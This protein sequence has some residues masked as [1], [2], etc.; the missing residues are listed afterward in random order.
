MAY[1]EEACTDRQIHVTFSTN[2]T[3]CCDTC[4]R[5]SGATVA[6]SPT[7]DTQCEPCI[8][9]KTFN[10]DPV[11][12]DST[13]RACATCDNNTHFILHPC[14]ATHNTLCVC[15]DGS[16]YDPDTDKCRFCELCGPGYGAAQRCGN[17]RNTVCEACVANVSYSNRHNYFTACTPCS[18]C[19][20]EEVMLKA[21]TETEDTIC[22]SKYSR[23]QMP[24]P[25]SCR[26]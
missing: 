3:K 19:S 26:S 21:C 8:P 2:D 24:K 14:N 18:T 9:G 10:S 25:E 6:C 5:G 17:G 15:P 13:C 11:S 22:F 23:L 12:Y 4:K 7:N 1:S 16:Y 20:E